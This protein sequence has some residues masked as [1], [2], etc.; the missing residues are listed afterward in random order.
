MTIFTHW[1]LWTPRDVV[2]I[3]GKSEREERD[4]E[5]GKQRGEERERGKRGEDGRE[6]D[7]LFDKKQKLKVFTH[8]LL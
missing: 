4:R 3:K 6:R 1:H 2:K 7:P 5:G 8:C